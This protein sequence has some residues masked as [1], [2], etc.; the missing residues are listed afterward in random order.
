M[1]LLDRLL[2]GFSTNG[3]LKA[4]VFLVLAGL[5]LWL[6][7]PWGGLAGL[8]VP[9]ADLRGALLVRRFMPAFEEDLR[10]AMTAAALGESDMHPG[11]THHEM[12]DY[13]GSIDH[14]LLKR[15][16]SHMTMTLFAPKRDYVVIARREGRIFPPVDLVRM[17]Y[18]HTDLGSRDV[19]YADVV[20]AEVMDG[21]VRLHMLDGNAVEY[22]DEDGGGEAAVE[23]L[24]KR[25]R[26]F[27]AGR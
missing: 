8:L 20:S 19:Y 7:P 18:A 23:E 24:R 5:G 26:A 2:I 9:L 3:P 13:S 6:L 21:L 1:E 10:E 17:T 27:K 15:L 4:L 12:L 14:W 25:L 11:D 22:E 16:P